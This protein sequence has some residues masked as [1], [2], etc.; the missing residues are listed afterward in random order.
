MTDSGTF[1]KDECVK[2][3][4]E[5]GLAL[6]AAEAI[7]YEFVYL[8]ACRYGETT[9]AGPFDTDRCVQRLTGA[10]L[11]RRVAEVIA[12]RMAQ[13]HAWLRG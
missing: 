3:M 7:A 13:N 6:P 4:T 12:E 11:A 8:D 5:A 2:D 1:D 10:G 9:D